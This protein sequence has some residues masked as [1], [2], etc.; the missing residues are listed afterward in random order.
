MQILR[1]EE[2]IYL[3]RGLQNVEQILEGRFDQA[4][5]AGGQTSIRR[6]DL[7]DNILRLFAESLDLVFYTEGRSGISG[8]ICG[9]LGN[10][11]ANS[12]DFGGDGLCLCVRAV[13]R[14][15]Q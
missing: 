10:I 4:L 9:Q 8:H 1:D 14:N 6:L 2:E 15:G 13:E 11:V 5:L 12:G 3:D 7:R